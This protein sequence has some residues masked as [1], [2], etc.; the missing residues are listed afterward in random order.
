[1]VKNIA[2][3]WVG[4]HAQVFRELRQ[5]S[6]I[7][8]EQVVIGSLWYDKVYNSRDMQQSAA[9]SSAQQQQQVDVKNS[10]DMA[11]LFSRF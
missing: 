6:S 2:E 4:E 1:M 5:S 3:F 9:T 8:N 10:A 11:N 7:L